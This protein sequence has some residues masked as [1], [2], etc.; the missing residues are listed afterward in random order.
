MNKADEYRAAD[1]VQNAMS[2]FLA[3]LELAMQLT[4]VQHQE[5]KDLHD[6]VLNHRPDY[7]AWRNKVEKDLNQ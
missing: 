6:T 2:N 3:M 1:V 4:T 5:L 7:T